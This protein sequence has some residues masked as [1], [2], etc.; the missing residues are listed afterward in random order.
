[1]CSRPVGK[2]PTY[3]LRETPLVV[4]ALV[5]GLTRTDLYRASS[6]SEKGVAFQD[7]DEVVTSALSALDE[8]IP[9]RSVVSEARNRW[10]SRIVTWLPCRTVLRLANTSPDTPPR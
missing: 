1:M 10:T 5:P 8:K 4:L 6:S 3:E 7:P 9:P 2:P